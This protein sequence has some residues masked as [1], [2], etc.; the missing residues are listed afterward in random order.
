MLS[1][2]NTL[3]IT[4]DWR[5][6]GPNMQ[7]LCMLA[8]RTFCITHPFNL[9]AE[10]ILHHLRRENQLLSVKFL[11]QLNCTLI[12]EVWHVRHL[13]TLFSPN[14]QKRQE[15]TTPLHSPAMLEMSFSPVLHADVVLQL[16]L[17][18]PNF[19]V[20]NLNTSAFLVRLE[21]KRGLWGFTHLPTCT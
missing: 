14:Y 20:L 21:R 7:S 2:E 4:V 9:V 8:T 10:E 19:E 6:T 12:H 5:C 17:H 3:Q 11:E 13:K 1:I 16:D 18:V 15:G